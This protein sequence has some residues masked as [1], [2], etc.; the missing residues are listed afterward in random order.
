MGL[1]R[2][3]MGLPLLPPPPLLPLLHSLCK[4]ELSILQKNGARRVV[5]EEMKVHKPIKKIVH[6]HTTHN[7]GT[8]SARCKG[9]EQTATTTF[10]QI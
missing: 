1:S 7:E 3:P 4:T 6:A 5:R 8:N 2:A 10:F 9:N